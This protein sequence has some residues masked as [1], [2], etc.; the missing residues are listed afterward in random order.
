MTG[1]AATL[2]LGDINPKHTSA[3][4]LCPRRTLGMWGF[5][6]VQCRNNQ[7]TLPTRCTCHDR[8][9]EGH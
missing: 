6:A 2:G 9:S 7:T 3:G 4:W 1:G 5:L 8:L